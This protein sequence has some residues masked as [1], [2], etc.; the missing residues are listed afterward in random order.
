MTTLGPTQR[1]AVNTS[2]LSGFP[3]AEAPT[4]FQT[5][6]LAADSLAMWVSAER[7]PGSGTPFLRDARAAHA[8]K[9]MAADTTTTITASGLNGHDYIDFTGSTAQGLTIPTFSLSTSYTII[10]VTRLHTSG[11]ACIGT[12]KTRSHTG[13][14]A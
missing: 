4:N 14:Y 8:I 12:V 2:R 11:A 9:K 7:A 6:I 1:F 3:V 5:S 13:M 10:A